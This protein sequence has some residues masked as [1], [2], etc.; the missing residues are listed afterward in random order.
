MISKFR[1]FGALIVMAC[2]TLPGGLACADIAIVVG[3]DTYPNLIQGN[4]QGCVNDA[5]AMKETLEGYG[6]HVILVTEDQATKQ[7]IL[8]ALNQVGTQIKPN[9]RFVFYF[10][11]HG[12]K[13]PDGGGVLLAHDI[14]EG[15][16]SK[17]ISKVELSGA[18][19]SIPVQAKTVLLDACYSD[20]LLRSKGLEKLLNLRFHQ[21]GPKSKRIDEVNHT[22]TNNNVVSDSVCA[23]ASST[24][25]QPSGET[26]RAGQIR[27]VFTY[28]LEQRLKQGQKTDRWGD[29]SSDVSTKVASE[30]EDQQTPVFGPAAYADVQVFEALNGPKPPPAPHRTLWD[31]YVENKANQAY[32]QMRVTPN[33]S[34]VPQNTQFSIEVVVGRE[35]GYL[36]LLNKDASGE[37]YLFSPDPRTGASAD[38]MV[39]A[40]HLT[41]GTTRTIKAIPRD[42]GTERVKAIL[43]HS[44]ADAKA[45]ISAFPPN[46]AQMA[47][48][49]RILRKLVYKGQS[50]KQKKGWDYFTSM[51][52]IDVVQAKAAAE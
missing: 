16:F 7:G 46:G 35:D 21:M 6:F 37:I 34:Q 30:M 13:T 26:D 47:D 48:L 36:V 31:D 49:R 22:D 14:A 39:A 45:L 23:F 33:L 12:S 3:N 2:F 10:A 43:F 52:E 51:I 29:V 28:H 44:E 11:G 17:A 41:S 38:A 15:D 32:L 50:D 9:E 18:L 4:L 5:R 19:T 8:S 1:F 42:L 20:G 25:L 27:G 24:R 40:S